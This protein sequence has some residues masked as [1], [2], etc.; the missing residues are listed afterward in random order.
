MEGFD[1]RDAPIFPM[2]NAVEKF[3][4]FYCSYANGLAGYL[5]EMALIANGSRDDM[6]ALAGARQA[7][8]CAADRRSSDA[9]RTQ[10][11]STCAGARPV[12]IT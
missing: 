7:I 6:P 4:C 11:S 12:A 2:L 3:R 10:S 9:S 5:R 8:R 1:T